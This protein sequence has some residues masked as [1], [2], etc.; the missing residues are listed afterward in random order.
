MAS[1]LMSPDRDATAR[2]LSS[3]LG[4]SLDDHDSLD[5]DESPAVS[6]RSPRPRKRSRSR[7]LADPRSP[8]AAKS[9]RTDCAGA[10]GR[11]ASSPLSSLPPSDT[12]E[13]RGPKAQREREKVAR[14]LRKLQPFDTFTLDKPLDKRLGLAP[15]GP[16]RPRTLARCTVVARGE[17]KECSAT[18]SSR[19]DV[20]T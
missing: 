20:R 8:P 6:E 13:E 3:S 9:A 1:A 4:L 2:A 5:E 11:S 15:N 12:E 18:Y 19:D 14:E 7:S 17:D 16:R 10:R